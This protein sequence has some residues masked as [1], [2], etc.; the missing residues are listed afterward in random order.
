MG[1]IT[2]R[3]NMRAP[4]LGAF[5]RM[6]L[7][8]DHTPPSDSCPVCC[9]GRAAEQLRLAVL[10][11]DIVDVLS[12]SLLYGVFHAEAV[13]TEAHDG[14]PSIIAH[15]STTR[16]VAIQREQFKSLGLH[17][18]CGRSSCGHMMQ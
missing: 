11:V 16:C 17:T 8:T 9:R 4:Q 12:G 5:V 6:S 2:M 14:T 15:A 3:G 18:P 7:T 1:T 13:P 10:L